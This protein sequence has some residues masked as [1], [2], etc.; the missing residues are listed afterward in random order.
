MAEAVSTAVAASIREVPMTVSDSG[1]ARALAVPARARIV[2]LLGGT[3]RPYA[4]EEIAEAVGLHVSTVRGHLELLCGVGLVVRAG[5]HRVGRGRPRVLYALPAEDAGEAGYRRLAEV[6]AAELESVASD[7]ARAALR[8]G[9]RWAAV[10]AGPGLD[11]HP[12]GDAD[13][14]L[15]RV[16][17]LLERLGFR[18][19]RPSGTDA[20]HLH[21]CPFEVAARH[22]PM[23]V[24]GVHLGLLRAA[25]ERLGG[26]VGVDTLDSFV[27]DEYCVVRVR[28]TRPDEPVPE[29]I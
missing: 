24:C 26:R 12:D 3:G 6:L 29:G 14:D 15:A 10:S 7:P 23:I 25:F 18:P 27:D 17:A 28:R 1:V 16:T 20:I 13:E 21:R 9:E 19:T 2:R 11:P 22:N 5:V 8:A 4:V